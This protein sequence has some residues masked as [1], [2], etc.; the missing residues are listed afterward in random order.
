[1]TKENRIIR[2]ILGPVKTDAS[3]LANAV[4]EA[5]RLLFIENV[6]MDDI[7]V[8]RDIY[9]VIAAKRNKVIHTVAR[10]IE[11]TS[12][13]C[14]DS[15]NESDKQRYI[16]KQIRDLRGPRDMIFYLAFYSWFGKGYYE[17]LN[18]EPKLLFGTADPR[19]YGF[20][21]N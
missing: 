11:R 7:R 20:I 13:M 18:E 17:V 3:I 4:Q 5:E 2:Y 10:Q 12:N 6:P 21:D 8:T 19:K 9:A 14:W 16:G 1:M 15:M